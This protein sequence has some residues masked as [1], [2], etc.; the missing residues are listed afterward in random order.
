MVFRTCCRCVA[1]LLP[2]QLALRHSPLVGLE[3]LVLV[4]RNKGLHLR[5]GPV[6]PG[7]ATYGGVAPL[8]PHRP[9]YFY[10]M[11]TL[12]RLDISHLICYTIHEQMF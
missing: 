9:N 3:Q 6:A 10:I 1:R 5:H 2:G 11:S 8:R 12:R 7:L 4:G